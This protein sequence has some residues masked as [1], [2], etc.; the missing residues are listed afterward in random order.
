M[1]RAVV[2]LGALAA[3]GL[4]WWTSQWL[5]PQPQSFVRKGWRSRAALPADPVEEPPPSA[6]PGPTP[7]PAASSPPETVTPEPA[8]VAAPVAPAPPVARLPVIELKDVVDVRLPFA[9]TAS[10][11]RFVRASQIHVLADESMAWVSA[12][13]SKD[14]SSFDQIRKGL[15]ART[16]DPLVVVAHPETSWQQVRGI[17]EAGQRAGVRKTWIGAALEAE[18]T[19]LR[20]L[21]FDQPETPDEPLP[22]GP[23]FRVSVSD[24]DAH[25]Y[26]VDGEPVTDFP[27]DLAAAWSAW[28][29]EHRDAADTKSPLTTRVVLEIDRSAPWQRVVALVDVLRE[30]GVESERVAPASTGFGE[31]RR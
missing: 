7:E 30:I 13:Q 18:P 20:V 2:V 19:K 21:S 11:P 29:R 15:A 22:G 4:G 24:D 3:A 12:G 25:P 17:V 1:N 31:R 23:Q 9:R 6:E 27:V 8:A 16:A 28:R 26:A 10:P 5:E 14:Q